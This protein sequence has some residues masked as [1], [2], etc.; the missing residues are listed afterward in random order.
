MSKNESRNR[1]GGRREIKKNSGI[2]LIVSFYV[3]KNSYY[4]AI[5]FIY[6]LLMYFY[7]H[8]QC[9]FSH[10]MGEIQ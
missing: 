5:I 7:I 6:T 10:F 1:D 4:H 3:I 8:L 2:K 9:I